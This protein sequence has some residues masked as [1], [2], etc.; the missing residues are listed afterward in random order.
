M[1]L[2]IDDAMTVAIV[3]SNFHADY[4]PRKASASDSFAINLQYTYILI[5]ND[6]VMID[7]LLFFGQIKFEA[8]FR[9]YNERF[10]NISQ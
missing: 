8:L 4:C 3:S 10:H 1:Q 2:P 5:D 7:Y 6:S 9:Q